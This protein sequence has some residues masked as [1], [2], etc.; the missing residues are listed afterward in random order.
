MQNGRA[1][2]KFPEVSTYR[3]SCKDES[4]RFAVENPATGKVITTIQAGDKETVNQAIQASQKAFDERWRPLSP[5][6]RS[7]YLFRC[8]H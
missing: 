4:K 1:N 5:R 2:F 6:E 7:L 3:Y 8:V